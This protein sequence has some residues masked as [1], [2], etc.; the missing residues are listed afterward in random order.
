MKT[1]FAH[2]LTAAL[3]ATEFA[4]IR[5]SSSDAIA[6]LAAAQV[7]PLGDT[8]PGHA[9]PTK[10]V[11]MPVGEHQ[12]SA[13]AADGTPWQGKVICDEAGAQAV[14]ATLARILA[15][16]HRVPLDKD[17]KDEEATAWVLGFSWDPA[18][19]IM[20]QV[21]WTSLGEQ[22]LRGKVYHS[23]SPAFLLNRK[24]SRVS[25]FPGGGHAAGSLVNAPAFGSAM[26]SLIAARLAGF[27]STNKPASGGSPD[28]QNKAMNKLLIQILA[29]LSVEVPANAT[30]DQLV[31][32]VT[33][34][35]D[36]LPTAGAEGIALKAQLAELTT[37]KA[38]DTAR[39]KADAK[40]AVDTAVARGAIPPKDDAIQAKWLGLIEANPD[41]AALLAAMPDNP[42]LTR[43]T[44]PGQG[45]T[46]EIQVEAKLLE[47]L[48][49]YAA[50]KDHMKAGVIY[51][52]HIDPTIAK[53]GND[54]LRVM[55]ANS[56]GS[57]ATAIILQRNLS[58][59]K[60]RFPF[61]KAITTDFSDAGAKFG[62]AVTTRLRSVPTVRDYHA[63]T[64]Y[65]TRSDA[66]TA[67]VS[68]TIDKHKYAAIEF[69]ATELGSTNRDLFG[70]QSEPQL[71]AL[72]Y[73]LVSDLL[74]IIAEGAA[75]FGTAGSQATNIAN[76]AAFAT[77]TLD[78]VAAALDLRKVS[79]IDRFALLD[80]TLWPTL[81]AD[82][83]LVYLAGFQDRSIIENY[84]TMPRVSGFQ[85]YNA[86]FLPNPV[87]NT[88]KA[89]HGFAG[90]PDA[91]A[92]AARLPNDYTTVLPGASAGNVRV[93]TEPDSKLSMMLVQYV[94]HDIGSA[95]S[96]VALMYGAAIGNKL[97]G[98]LISY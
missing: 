82:T 52:R 35:V 76:A 58:L 53:Q 78:A 74:A 6:V 40:T 51:A 61:L 32:L 63:T 9:L 44:Q 77:T 79:P 60:F 92:L 41:H 14:S 16:G 66:T 5:A 20:V 65:T 54:V 91:L 72:G 90:G 87:V 93:I 57:S 56:L 62:Q 95:I 80:S 4:F 67:D 38:A 7:I 96:R 24:T 97:N 31:A 42:A 30:E 33:K 86:P 28:N 17:H 45:G 18:Q 81:R 21:E 29:A 85:P 59:L 1:Y 71:Y 55:A 11:W 68:I 50:E 43:V 89:A 12:I 15:A 34:H 69:N 73:Q 94:N 70:E 46:T 3:F 64:G 47:N 2:G 22:L 75:A 26:P 25:G 37:L 27:E 84:D 39:R 36:K 98:Q 19:G 23:F 49:A 13:F 88:D 83:R 8:S 10:F 48:K